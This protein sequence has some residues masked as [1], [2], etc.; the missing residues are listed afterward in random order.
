MITT[1]SNYLT[2]GTRQEK[3][4]H[5]LMNGTASTVA[6]S[7]DGTAVTGLSLTGQNLGSD[8]I[9][10]LQ[11]GETSTGRTY[12]IALDDVVVAQTSL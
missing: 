6:F 1:S 5:G 12:D 11:L 4:R 7:L 2:T 10:K 8:P 3:V 9:A